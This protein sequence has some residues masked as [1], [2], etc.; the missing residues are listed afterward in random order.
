MVLLEN[1]LEEK[2]FWKKLSPAVMI[3]FVSA[4]ITVFLV[5]GY[6]FSHILLNGDA[7]GRFYAQYDGANR[8]RWF[9]RIAQDIANPMLLPWFSGVMS[10]IIIGIS[11]ALSVSIMQIKKQTSAM[12][13]GSLCASFPSITMMMIHEYSRAATFLGLMLMVLGT[14]FIAKYVWGFIPGIICIALSLGIY[15]AYLGYGC[16]LLIYLLLHDL[17]TQNE[18]E[19]AMRT[20]VIKALKYAGCLIAGVI[21]YY[22]I[23][24][25][26]CAPAVVADTDYITD[27]I[28]QIILTGASLQKIFTMPFSFFLAD[29]AKQ[30]YPFM[31]WVFGVI[32]FATVAILTVLV[33]T[34]RKVFHKW[35]WWM[36]ALLLVALPIG[37]NILYILSSDVFGRMMYPLVAALFLPLVLLDAY[38]LNE[39]KDLTH[40]ASRVAMVILTICFLIV[41][42]GYML[43]ADKTYMIM[44]LTYERAYSYSVKLSA[45]IE[46]TEGY[47]PGMPLLTIGKFGRVNVPSVPEA[48]LNDEM[49]TGLSVTD[50]SYNLLIASNY[51]EF[52]PVLMG[53]RYD[54][55]DDEDVKEE[56]KAI[57]ETEIADMPVYPAAGSICVFDG[58]VVLKLEGDQE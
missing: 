15:Q 38:P 35:Q 49:F 31:P 48:P 54:L 9:A 1:S 43:F 24:S 47:E 14:F 11:A 56:I 46:A 7:M 19:H 51:S 5:H 44:K 40:K 50:V 25:L 23:T 28:G 57:H 36:L 18:G 22:I 6:S 52:A 16:A 55:L 27:G 26:T 53:T 2:P 37:Y 42:H 10:M 30:C 41:N 17:L 34:K 12:L 33:A 13:I 21:V 4:C 58:V 3:A 32:G 8:G 45:R 29:S 20:F 39:I